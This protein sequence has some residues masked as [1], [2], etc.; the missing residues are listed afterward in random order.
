MSQHFVDQS[1][2]NVGT[3][4]GVQNTCKDIPTKL[5]AKVKLD[6]VCPASLA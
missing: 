5:K 1:G 4:K 6:D 3:V 2:S